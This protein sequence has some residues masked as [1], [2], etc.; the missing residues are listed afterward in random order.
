[1]FQVSLFY[2]RIEED[3]EGMCIPYNYDNQDLSG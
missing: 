1:M 3:V 2:D